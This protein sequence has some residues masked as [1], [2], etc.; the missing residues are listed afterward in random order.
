[1]G[2]GPYCAKDLNSQNFFG[3]QRAADDLVLAN[4]DV[5]AHVAST[6]GRK[7]VLHQKFQKCRRPAAA[8]GPRSVRKRP[9]SVA[10]A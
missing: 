4:V 1:M 5:P 3:S 6:V 8:A 10:F 9:A 2:D 7:F